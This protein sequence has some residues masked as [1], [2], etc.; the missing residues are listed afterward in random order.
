MAFPLQPDGS[1]IQMYF[2]NSSYEWDNYRPDKM[3]IRCSATWDDLI[4]TSG[5]ERQ[6]LN[7]SELN[8]KANEWA[9]F[10]L[11][12]LD[13]FNEHGFMS[14]RIGRNPNAP[15]LNDLGAV[16]TD[17]EFGPQELQAATPQ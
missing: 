6:M 3:R 13:Q 10:H 11:P 12:W 4:V 8:I 9:V 14:I 7:L 5:L 1:E 16:M 15:T 17:I 2:G